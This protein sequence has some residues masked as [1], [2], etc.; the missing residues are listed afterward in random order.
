MT[1]A[2]LKK[3]ITDQPHI[4]K[5][6]TLTPGGWPYVCPVW[7]NFD[8]REFTIAGR[9]KAAW[10]ANIRND[11]RV[12]LCIDTCDAPYNRVLIQAT[13][14]IVDENWFPPEPDRAI[15]YLG[16]EAGRR[17]F[18]ENKSVPRAQIRITPEKITSW[19]GGDWHPRY[20]K[21]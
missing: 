18:E 17:Y 2:Q 10:V 1:R 16:E 20:Y 11:S 14:K 5:L 19:S 6:A 4:M 8:G 21:D 9:L 7:Y 15:R 12:S 3:F 13:A